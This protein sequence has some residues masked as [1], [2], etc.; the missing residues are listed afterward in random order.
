MTLIFVSH[1]SLGCSGPKLLVLYSI[2]VSHQC[3]FC[4]ITIWTGRSWVTCVCVVM[5][6]LLELKLGVVLLHMSF[7]RYLVMEAISP[8][9]S[10][11]YSMK[12][13]VPVLCKNQ[14][15]C[16]VMLFCLFFFLTKLALL[17]LMLFKV[18]FDSGSKEYILTQTLKGSFYRISSYFCVLKSS[19]SIMYYVG[20]YLVELKR[21]F[22]HK[23]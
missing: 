9:I 20:I 11:L 17:P 2:F 5:L 18:L 6:K 21:G 7:L 1:F 10:F 3:N 8:F 19:S 23:A 14:T 22:L 12:H 16:E 13:P 15:V 4:P